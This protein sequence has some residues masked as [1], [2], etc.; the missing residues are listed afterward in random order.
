MLI[1]EKK[2]SKQ[3]KIDIIMIWTCSGLLLATA[4]LYMW[5]VS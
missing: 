2:M 4:L 5:S 3:E 1:P